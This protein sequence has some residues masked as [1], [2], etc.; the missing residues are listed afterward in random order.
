VKSYLARADTIVIA[1]VRDLQ[2][3]SVTDLHG[4]KLGPGSKLI[5][6]KLGNTSDND[7]ESAI[8]ELQPKHGI[9]NLDTVIA[10]AGLG[11]IWQPIV[12]STPSQAVEYFGVNAVGPM[13]LSWLL[14]LYYPNL[15]LLGLSSC[16]PFWAVSKCKANSQCPTLSMVCPKQ[17]LTSS[18]EKSTTSIQT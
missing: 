16:P 3:G 12:V 10:N 15:L 8:Q 4:F 7:A 14:Y 17:R 5:V 1:T 9:K 6:V 13:R 11:D 18:R 2:H